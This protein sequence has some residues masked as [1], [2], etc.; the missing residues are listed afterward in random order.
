[1]TANEP[2]ADKGRL[3][4]VAVEAHGMAEEVHTVQELE[5]KTRG[6][7]LT[8]PCAWQFAFTP[9]DVSVIAPEPHVICHYS[10]HTMFE[11]DKTSAWLHDDVCMS[12]LAS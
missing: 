2:P 9:T 1:V 5:S 3:R 7:Q 4:H 6:C 10:L 11:N 12:S 8:G